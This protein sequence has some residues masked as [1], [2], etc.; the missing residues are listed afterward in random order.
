M[1]RTRSQRQENLFDITQSKPRQNEISLNFNKAVGLI[2]IIPTY[3]KENTLLLMEILIFWSQKSYAENKFQYQD[4][5]QDGNQWN[6]IP[7]SFI[8]EVFGYQTSNKRY[9]IINM[10]KELVGTKV[11]YNFLNTDKTIDL[12]FRKGTAT[13]LSQVDYLEK[14]ETKKHKKYSNEIRY[15]FSP[16]FNTLAKRPKI[17]ANIDIETS[18]KLSLSARQLYQHF[19]YSLSMKQKD[20]GISEMSFE[21]LK[22]LVGKKDSKASYSI[23][24]RDFLK[25]DKEN[26]NN[27]TDINLDYEKLR[28]K[29]TL[30]FKYHNKQKIIQFEKKE[31]NLEQ[32]LSAKELE[33][34]FVKYK[35][36]V[37]I[38]QDLKKNYTIRRIKDNISYSEEAFKLK[39]K[40][41]T[42]SYIIK[43]IKEDYAKSDET[44]I[45]EE[46]TYLLSELRV[47]LYRFNGI[48]E[49]ANLQYIHRYIGTSLYLKDK[50][51]KLTEEDWKSNLFQESRNDF[52]T[53]EN[54]QQITQQHLINELIKI[55]SI[56][57]TLEQNHDLKLEAICKLWNTDK[58]ELFHKLKI[59]EKKFFEIIKDPQI[60]FKS[61]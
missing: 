21:A 38:R 33:D 45:L 11:E 61:H 20:E 57:Q 4:I 39:S 1:D 30:I 42:F 28:G 19:K 9:L 58:A 29:D 53:L 6:I 34:L 37:K 14:S 48:E 44:Q 3:T 59:E 31:E 52:K 26:I 24:N 49:S 60:L 32:T 2:D 35:I 22:Q 27:K 46:K 55:N 23:Y 16:L 47:M 43:A 15:A 41:P 10:L 5:D 18:K 25:K 51:I 36:D 40:L 17:F 13:I 8:E 56:L 7:F 50:I 12:N 54:F